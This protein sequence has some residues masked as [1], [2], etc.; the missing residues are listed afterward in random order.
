MALAEPSCPNK[1]RLLSPN[2][3]VT[4]HYQ[5]SAWVELVTIELWCKHVL[6]K[7][8]LSSVLPEP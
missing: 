7:V 5:K 2:L 8:A 6:V 3:L 1:G 4:F